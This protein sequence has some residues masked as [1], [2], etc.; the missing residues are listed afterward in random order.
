MNQDR[1]DQVV[2]T[3][4]Y[5][6]ECR[7]SRRDLLRAAAAGGVALAAA[8][9]LGHPPSLIARAATQETASQQP[10]PQKCSPTAWS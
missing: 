9:G 7:R 4:T 8:T 6:T 3:L 10:R 5:A 2:R 1:V